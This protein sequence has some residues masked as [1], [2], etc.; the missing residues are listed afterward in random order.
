MATV[1]AEA[2]VQA[3]EALRAQWP[4]HFNSGKITELGELFYAEDARALPG[5]H[6]LVVGRDNITRFLREVRDSG[7]VRFELGVIETK[8]SGDMGYLVGTYVFTDPEGVSHN[9]FTLE[10][11]RLQDDG[12]WK[13]AVDMWHHAT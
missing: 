5:Q 6:D 12:V 4:E 1:T 10:T 7:D 11:Y 3:I 9:G 8:V 13:C 2:G